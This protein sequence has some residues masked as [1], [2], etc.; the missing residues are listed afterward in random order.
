MFNEAQTW[1]RRAGQRPILEARARSGSAVGPTVGDAE[2]RPEVRE[3]VGA[4]SIRQRA[5]VVLTYW[6]DL[7]PRA[8]AERL[9]IS[10][11]SVRRHLA[12]P[13]P[14]SGRLSMPDP[15][16]DAALDAELRHIAEALVAEAP[17]EVPPFPHESSSRGMAPC[18]AARG[19]PPSLQRL[20][21][22]SQ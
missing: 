9:G 22:S 15:T 20:R 3:A 8:V 19:E 7:A 17:D 13:V 2:L 1:R 18:G 12:G 4:L 14:A 6:A 21:W 11:G 16:T 10:E 5:V